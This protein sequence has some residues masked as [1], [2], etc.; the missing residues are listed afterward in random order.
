MDRTTERGQMI[1]EMLILVL[2]FAGFFLVAATIAQ[3]SE[4]QQTKYRF[5]KQSGKFR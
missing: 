5:T 4:T 3:S 1:L 2:M